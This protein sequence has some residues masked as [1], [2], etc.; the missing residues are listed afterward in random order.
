MANQ[1][2]WPLMPPKST[3]LRLEHFDED[4]Y[5]ADRLSTLYKFIDALCGDAGAGSLKKEIFMARLGG[6]LENI[7]FSDLDY[8]FGNIHFLSRTTEESY[9]H[10]PATQSLTSDQWDDVRTK[11]AWYRARI[12][13]FFVAC[14]MGGTTDGIRMAVQAATSADCDV[15]EVWRYADVLQAGEVGAGAE[16]IGSYLGRS[17]QTARNEV[18]IIPHK[19]E[20]SARESRL[21]RDML[22]RICPVDTI[23]TVEKEG[24]LL[25][26]P[27]AVRS[28]AADSSY[29][30]V[31]KVVTPTPLIEDLPPPELL[32]IDLDPTEQWLFKGS[33][34]LAPYRAFNIS[35][36]YGYYYLVGGGARSPIDS[37][38]YGTLQPDGGV[39][40][41]KSLELYEASGQYTE[42]QEYEIADSPDNYP[43][44]KFGLTP[45]ASPA[46]NAD[47]SPYVFAYESQAAYVE[48]MKQQVAAVG[49]E[50]DDAHYRLPIQKQAQNKRVYSPDLAIAYSAPARDSSVTTPWIQRRQRTRATDL[51]NANTFV[52]S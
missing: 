7:Y 48:Q 2:P 12:K 47:R 44:G 26:T 30:E 6:A 39:L 21:L 35:S 20:L 18:T 37:V 41:E 11:D 32:A 16:G 24:M 33:P 14:T 43:G 31:Q 3:E 9:P 46:L 27:L 52:R 45:S 51:R 17:P 49:G 23:I 38:T 10:E 50:A 34:E 40:P 22:S 5:R 15:Q 25:S 36:E 13:D 28:A 1:T 8:I 42:W 19:A 29:Y 4:V